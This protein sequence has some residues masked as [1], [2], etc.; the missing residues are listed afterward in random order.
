[1]IDVESR[2][3]RAGEAA[4]A[5]AAALVDRLEVATTSPGHRVRPIVARPVI[6]A[7]VGALVVLLVVLLVGELT[8]PGVPVI[9]PAVPDRDTVSEPVAV[10]GVLPVPSVGE[11]IA[12]YLE[13]GTP[14]F[15]S[16]PEEGDVRV[17]G[18]LNPHV[19]AWD[20][21]LVAYC[22]SSGWF[23]DLRHGSRFN[24][25]GD[26][27]GG[28]APSALP[29]HEADVSVDG[30]TVRVT[31]E[32]VHTRPR[33]D[34]RAEQPQ[35]G[36]NCVDPGPAAG[37]TPPATP[38]AHEV[39]SVVPPLDGTDIPSDRWVWAEVRLGGGVGDPRACDR[40]GRCPADAPRLV[41]VPGWEHPVPGG[42]R[43]V[44]LVRRTPE[45]VLVLRPAVVP[46][47]WHEGAPPGGDGEQLGAARPLLPLPEPGGVLPAWLDDSTPVFVAHRADGTVHVLDATSTVSGHDLV[48]WCRSSGQFGEVHGA[49]WT[50]TGGHVGGPA[51]GDLPRY[52]AEVVESGQ[53]AA[54]RV[55]GELGAEVGRSQLTD[56]EREPRGPSCGTDQLIRHL[57]GGRT[58]V[59]ERG[60][61]GGA[62]ARW[63]WVRMVIA[64]V[65][66][67]LLLCAVNGPDACG[68][69]EVE[70]DPTNADCF[71]DI[72]AE[73][74]CPADEDPIVVTE[75]VTPS[76]GPELLLVRRSA[77]GRTVEVRRP[78]V[79]DG[80]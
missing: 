24:A 56:E 29:D 55:T 79:A 60:L 38:V 74:L 63:V 34:T 39:P 31:G 70:V 48:G 10:D 64:E 12:A 27:M 35:R 4:R 32:S 44:G 42:G 37:A 25:W 72:G 51:A 8:R 33:D 53:T 49:R 3:R 76:A 1:M 71:D 11:A 36:P 46:S 16:H 26:W 9:E 20:G 22:P 23:E 47:G 57:P 19:H 73:G 58:R 7:V 45:G 21:K 52:P 15:V 66:G 50:E 43:H 80:G 40:D 30:Q 65:D 68:E 77:D 28:P 18:A 5:E 69:A 59:S 61:V 62:D 75:G 17:V 2:A 41:T 13:D 54:V 78:A 6:G 67:Q 14:V